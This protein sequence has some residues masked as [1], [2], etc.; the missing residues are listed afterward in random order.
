MKK[1]L[2]ALFASCVCVVA[3]HAQNN[4]NR[5]SIGAGCLYENG[6][7]LTLSY[8]HEMRHHTSWEFFANGYLKWDECSSCK[9][10]CPE[11]FWKNYRSYCFGV[12]YKPCITRG[13]NNFGNVRIGASA[14]S[15]TNRFLGGIHLGYEH[16]YALNSGWMLFWQVKTD[17]MIKGEDLFRTGIVLGFKLPV[18]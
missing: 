13:R 2:L 12:A 4:S 8:E 11:S 6:L 18:K 10:I 1:L 14:G 9:H 16:N 3:A 5:I 7:D 15:D 17:L